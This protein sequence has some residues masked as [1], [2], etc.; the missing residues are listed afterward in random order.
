MYREN[1]A[2]DRVYKPVSTFMVHPD[3]YMAGGDPWPDLHGLQVN[4]VKD[5]LKI[6][7]TKLR[8]QV[9]F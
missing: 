6:N 8:N 9:Y 7:L 1:V 2:G 4:I 3:V 5:E